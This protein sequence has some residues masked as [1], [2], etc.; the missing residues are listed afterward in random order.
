MGK[1]KAEKLAKKQAQRADQKLNASVEQAKSWAAPKLES[2]MAWTE[3]CLGNSLDRAE[4]A[5]YT[6]VDKAGPRAKNAMVSLTDT[7]D[8]ARHKVQDQYVPA[9]SG[10]LAGVAGRASKALSTADIPKPVADA[11]VKVTG[12]KKATK[13]LRKAAEDY[14]K[15]AEKSLN[16]QSK[17]AS[18]S[19]SGKTWMIV[20]VVVTA[21]G[22]A[23]AAYQ[24][25]KPVEDP[26]KNP[27]PQPLNDN[28]S[29]TPQA[30][31]NPAEPVDA[32]KADSEPNHDTEGGAEEQVDA[33]APRP[34]N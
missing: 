34:A 6:A 25:T 9:A 16:K 21:G 1:R 23:Y 15:S 13:K 30:A 5:A 10:Q 2:A 11:M 24:L 17:K 32:V 29:A 4:K 18:K 14:A 33:P 27:T 3:G 19:G 20:G 8:S 12:D 26:W 22:A 31:S 28:T 7:F